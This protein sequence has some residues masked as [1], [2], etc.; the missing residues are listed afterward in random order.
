MIEKVGNLV[1]RLELSGNMRI[2]P[3]I[4]VAKLE[5]ASDRSKDPYNRTALLPPPVEEEDDNPALTA[6]QFKPYEIERLLDRR[7]EAGSKDVKY[8]VKWKGYGTHYN[9]WYPV[10][11]LTKSKELMKECDARI[12]A[13]PTRERRQRRRHVEVP[14]S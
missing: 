10:Y 5:P 2:Y 6:K 12:A 1:Y 8:L 14:T 11:A 3:V 13:D 9:V 4:S 7:G